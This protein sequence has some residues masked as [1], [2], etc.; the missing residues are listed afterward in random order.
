[1][2]LDLDAYRAAR[3]EAR[4]EAPTIKLLGETFTMPVEVPAAVLQAFADD[5][6]VAFGK[7]V[8]GDEQWATFCEVG[9]TE[10]DLVV[11]ASRLWTLYGVSL[12]ESSV[13]SG[14]SDSGGEHL[15]PTSDGSTDSTSDAS[16]GAEMAS[17]SATSPP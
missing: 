6:K 12:G 1:M 17:A 10:D 5:D 2:E 11:I 7:A 8:L 14:S 9:G 13:S 16:S 3:A 4:G 15:R